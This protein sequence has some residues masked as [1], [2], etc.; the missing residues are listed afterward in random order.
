MTLLL[1]K[2]PPLLALMR[3]WYE[4]FQNNFINRW[5][6]CEDAPLISL[7]GNYKEITNL[8]SQ[9]CESKFPLL[10][11]SCCLGD[12]SFCSG[13]R[14]VQTS[15]WQRLIVPGTETS[16]AN[17]RGKRRKDGESEAPGDV[18]VWEEM[19]AEEI[20]QFHPHPHRWGEVRHLNQ[21]CVFNLTPII[22]SLSDSGT[23][24]SRKLH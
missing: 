10:P 18:S 19:K 21:F 2:L 20:L 5:I 15:V 23:T 7:C 12:S 11:F 8:K 6:S 1:T 3:M 16:R 9:K 22:N 4:S 13:H 14:A 17:E 24:G